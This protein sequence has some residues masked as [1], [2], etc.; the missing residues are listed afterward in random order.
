MRNNLLLC[1]VL[2]LL[3]MLKVKLIIKFFIKC[4]DYFHSSIDLGAGGGPGG[5]GCGGAWRA[6]NKN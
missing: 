4:Y 3:P 5:G 1:Y 6:K 2:Y